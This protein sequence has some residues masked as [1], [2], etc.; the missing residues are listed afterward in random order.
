MIQIPRYQQLAELLIQQINQN[1]LCP[2]D[3]LPSVRSFSRSQKVSPGTVLN[4]YNQLEQMQ[5]IEAR[6]QSG[7]YVRQPEPETVRQPDSASQCTDPLDVTMGDLALQVVTATNSP[8]N[9]PMGPAYP[10]N[11]FRITRDLWRSVARQS[12][13]LSREQPIAPLGYSVPP[14]EPAL[15]RQLARQYGPLCTAINPD[16]L[17]ITNGCQEALCL[18][19][20]AVCCSGDI[21]AVESP[22][23]Y[24]TLQLIESLGLKIVEIPANPEQGISLEALRLA[25]Q[26]WPVKAVLTSANIGNPLGYLMPDDNKQRLLQLLQQYDLPLIEDDVFGDLAYQHS[27]PLPIKAFDTDGRVLWCSSVSK[28]IDPGVRIGWLSAGRYHERVNYLKYV[29]TMASPA[30]TQNAVA[31]LLAGNTYNRHLRQIRQVYQ[32][33]RDQLINQLQRY[34]PTRCRM[35]QPRGGFLI[36]LE[37][38]EQIDSLTLHQQ[39]LR[40][41]ISIAPGILFSATDN[42]RHCIRLNY[43]C[44]D[45]TSF[46]RAIERLGQWLDGRDR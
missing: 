23:F 46:C 7:Y 13:T 30:A 29:S 11:E 42:Y 27:R 1:I 45:E 16:Q 8:V 17:V 6:P 34:L 26:Q 18:S 33:R 5:L 24:G 21:I 40:H 41:Q 36:W 25:L 31:E 39:A 3:K 9:I 10:S 32:R 19:L 28:T 2:G 35:T 38:P 20:Q 4:C 44:Y 43:A 15:L 14:G 22:V 12:R 37:L